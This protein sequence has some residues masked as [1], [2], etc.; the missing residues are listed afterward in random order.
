MTRFPDIPAEVMTDAQRT[1]RAAILAGPRGR[2]SGPFNTWLRNPEM[3]MPAQEL[4][5]YFRFGTSLSRD[6][7]EIAICV[8]AVH[9]KA[10]YEWWAHSRFAHEAGV[11]EAVTEAIRT[12]QEPVFDDIKSRTVYGVA[13]ALNRDHGL[14]DETFALARQILGEQGLVD[15]IGLCGYYAMVS[16]TLNVAQVPTPDGSRPFG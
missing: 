8:T 14:D 15:V 9:Y 7:A 11:P 3:A 1:V 16:L 12:G 5:T 13:L 2:L 4:G 10:E 6:L